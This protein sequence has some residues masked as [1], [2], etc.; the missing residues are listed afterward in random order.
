MSET[1]SGRDPWEGPGPWDEWLRRHGQTIGVNDFGYEAMF[2]RN[3]LPKVR[4]LSPAEVTPQKEVMS[5]GRR[6]RID[7]AVER[8]GL[9]IAVEIDGWDKSGTGTGMTRAEYQD[10]LDRQNELV[11]AGWMVM[12]FTPVQVRDHPSTLIDRIT[13]ALA[14]H[15]AGAPAPAEVLQRASAVE[16]PSPPTTAGLGGGSPIPSRPP[17]AGHGPGIPSRVWLAA[18]VVA[19]VIAG[20]L[21]L[22]SGGSA[23]AGLTGPR[24]VSCGT[25]GV[26]RGNVSQSGVLIYHLPGDR[27]YDV[28]NP[29]EC[30]ATAADAEAAGYRRAKV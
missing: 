9:K 3:V 12:R 25:S 11:L 1:R 23:D 19:A 26:A 2:A 5:A 17:T 13:K 8:P 29:E 24:G 15:P 27:Y 21:L 14:G 28:T 30:F 16:P 6:R 10:F 7:F 18:G 22:A 4:G 20:G